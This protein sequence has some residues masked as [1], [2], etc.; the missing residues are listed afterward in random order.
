VNPWHDFPV[1]SNPPEVVTAVVEIPRGSRNKFELDKQSG[2]FRLD[3]LLYSAVHYP[4][5]YGFIPRTLAGDNDPLDVLIMT[6]V[7]TFTGCLIEARPLGIFVMHDR[8]ETDEKIL[9]VPLRDP[10]YAEYAELE[11]VAPHFLREVEHFFAIYKD[12]EG[13]RAK[14]IGWS[15]RR[16]AAEV[17]SESM[18]RYRKGYTDRSSV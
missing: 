17:I 13:T 3:R 9:A 1:G 5:D 11:D 10:L 12:L 18:Q 8:D 2:M 6:T 14:V 7:P 4:G 15:D 16:A